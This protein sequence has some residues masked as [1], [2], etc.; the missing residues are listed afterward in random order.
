MFGKRVELS[1][2]VIRDLCGCIGGLLLEGEHHAIIAVDAAVDGCRIVRDKHIRNILQINGIHAFHA[3]IKQHQLLQFLE[4]CNLIAYA[5]EP[6]Y[7][8]LLHIARRHS[9]ILRL[10]DVC[11]HIHRNDI[12]KVGLLKR[13]IACCIKLL[14]PFLNLAQRI[15]KLLL[16][17]VKLG[18]RAIQLLLGICLFALER[19]EGLLK[20]RSAACELALRALQLGNAAVD[21]RKPIRQLRRCRRQ[22]GAG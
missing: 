21:L 6:V 14:L 3:R 19:F 10:E 9:E 2:D 22:I 7:A 11:D 17:A 13:F 8:I 18:S 15:G 4:G 20:L 16:A 12:L 1:A 5:D